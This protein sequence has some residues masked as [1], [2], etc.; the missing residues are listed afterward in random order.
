MKTRLL[1]WAE[2]TI[3]NIFRMGEKTQIGC[4]S[5]GYGKR[6]YPSTKE[7][8][9]IYIELKETE[10]SDV[11]CPHCKKKALVRMEKVIS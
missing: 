9:K 10:L 2:W 6:N 7:I 11:K 5:C 4:K 8:R 1:T 3:N